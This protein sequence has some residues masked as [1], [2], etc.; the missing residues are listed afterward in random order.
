MYLKIETSEQA[1]MIEADIADKIGLP[2]IGK[3]T[4]YANP[5]EWEGYFYLPITNLQY[6]DEQYH[7][8]SYVAEHYGDIPQVTTKEYGALFPVDDDLDFA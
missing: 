7:I 1:E 5:V 4:R 3:A 6:K 2:D 8:A